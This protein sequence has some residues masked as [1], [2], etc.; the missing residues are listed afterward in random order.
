MS[1]PAQG[2]GLPEVTG[3]SYAH[4]TGTTAVLGDTIGRDLDRAIAA[5]GNREAPVVTGSRAG[6]GSWTPSR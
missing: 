3:P 2:S 5:H 4:G 1:E 6:C